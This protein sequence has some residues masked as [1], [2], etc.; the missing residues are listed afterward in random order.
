[1]YIP[2]RVHTAFSLAE[3]AIRIH[4]LAKRC[5][6][7]NLPAVSITDTNNLFGAYEFS[8]EIS[9]AGAQPIIGCEISVR[10]P[11]E[12]PRCRGHRHALG[13]DKLILL[14]KNG[15]GYKNLIKISSQ[16]FRNGQNGE[17]E[18]P[19]EFIAKQ[20][21]DLIALTGGTEGAVGKLLAHQ[22]FE[23]AGTTLLKLKE[24]FEDRLY[25]EI[26]RQGGEKEAEIEEPLLDL[27]YKHDLPIVA[28]NP[29]YFLDESIYEAHEVLLCI[30]G[31]NYI[32]QEDR[33]KSNPHYILKTPEEMRQLF[34]DLPEALNS[35][36]EIAKRC[37]FMVRGSKPLLP[38]FKTPLGEKEE[39]RVQAHKGLENRLA[40]QVFTAKHSPSEQEALRKE[41]TERLDFELSVIDQM[42]F[43]GYFL[44]VADFIGWAFD[45]AIPVGPGRGSGAGSVAAW[46]LKITGLDPIKFG[47]LFERFLNPER[48]SMPDFDIDFCQDRRDEVINYVAQKYGLDHVGQ[49]ITFGKLQARVVIRDVGRVLQMPYGQVD[50]L[51]KLIPNNPANPLSLKEAI[52]QEPQLQE[53]RKKDE[54]VKRL[55]KIGL[56]LEGLYRHAS[57]HAAGVVI[58]S[59][60]LEESVGLCFDS[61]SPLPITQ[62]NMKDT[63]SLGLVKFDFLGLK[64]LSV[65]QKTVEFIARK[66]HT[67]DL[68]T[69]P[70]DDP[71]TYQ[72]LHR[73][74]TVGVFQLEGA[75]M[76]DVVGKM[77]PDHIEEIIALISLYRPGPMDNIPKYIACKHQQEAVTYPHPLLEDV[78]KE[79]YGIAV[80]QEQVMKIAQVF[81]GYT[82]GAADL[83]RRA[84]GKKIKDEMDA[85]RRVF[86]EGAAATNAISEKAALSVFEQ[87]A[88]FAGYGFNKSHAAAYAIIAYQTAYLKANYPVEFMAA[89]MAYDISNID[90]LTVFRQELE[91]M[92]IPVLPPDINASDAS[93]KGEETPDGAYGIRYALGALK[94][95]GETA[96]KAIV[97]ERDR[98]GPYK[99]IIDFARRL[100]TNVINKR[101][102]EN[103]I[104]AGAFDSLNSNRKQLFDNLGLIMSFLGQAIQERESKQTSL[105]GGSDD[106]PS[107]PRVKLSE[108]GEWTIFDQLQREFDAIGFYLTAHPLEAYKEILKKDH[109][110]KAKSLIEFLS[111]GARESFKLAGIII[112]KQERISK[113]SGNRFAFLQLSDETG[114]FEVGVF[115]DQFIRYRDMFE[116][117]L[118]VSIEVAGRVE[119]GAL[120]LT[121][122]SVRKLEEVLAA[123]PNNIVLKIIEASA[124]KELQKVLAN[125]SKGRSSVKIIVDIDTYQVDLK[126][127]DDYAIGEPQRSEI[128]S[129]KGLKC[130]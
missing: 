85:Q 67:I 116:I 115:S 32:S 27:A 97:E 21:S 71:A 83:L 3:G 90:K 29:A 36:L 124:L 61:R 104:Q 54:S 20:A 76:R 43:N 120:K 56:K 25:V 128:F 125:F 40:T 45:N 98:N 70:L 123:T 77:K 2:L 19:L 28:T 127:P 68:D 60:P 39:L 114:I 14:A 96:M 42:G 17:V 34:A 74:E 101:Q 4:E 48:V 107:L 9:K 12:D 13:S 94:N 1:M 110:V 8:K 16:A 103:L 7:L 55:L 118:A 50:R 15:Q 111:S 109:K 79:T 106:K 46:C 5:K 130:A 24:I 41:Y 47:L 30:A 69:I 35:T 129:I 92:G 99:D 53:E 59:K 84:M 73:M 51:C 82:L 100:E 93:F 122:K 95:V 26:T 23:G 65:L 52:D 78:L 31:G 22:F 64:T 88:K 80:Y 66:N 6:E 10:I 18:V 87:V 33:R 58:A 75:G 91:R 44:I 63:E 121:L 112:S 108:Q 49:I 117:G 57:T 37:A 126:L 119:E 11:L 89:S 62:S 86:V 105:F 38:N 72:L 81:A 113:A 102:L